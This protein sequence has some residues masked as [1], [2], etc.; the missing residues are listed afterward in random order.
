M[1]AYMSEILE[2]LKYLHSCGVI[3]CDIKLENLLRHKPEGDTLGTMK[4]ADFGLAHIKDP[5]TGLAKMEVR[6]GSLTYMAPECKTG[7]YFNE[8]LDIWSLGLCLYQMAVAYKPT[9]ISGY[10]YGS[11]P[12]PFRPKDWNKRSPELRELLTGMLQYDP[13]KRISASEALQHPW[14]SV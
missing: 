9:A 2:G 13:E 10:K 8:K 6:C 1:K 12:I 5:V 14:F 3:H 4:I 11:G 7:A